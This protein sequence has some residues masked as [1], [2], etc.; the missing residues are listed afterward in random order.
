[1]IAGIDLHGRR[2]L[3][4]GAADG[5]GVETAR[6]LASAGAETV[7][8]ARDLAAAER[9]AASMV[10]TSVPIVHPSMT[11]NA[12]GFVGSFAHVGPFR[13][14]HRT[15]ATVRPMTQRRFRGLILDF[16]GVLTSNMVEVIELFEAREH[17]RPG[18][19]LKSWASAEGQELYRQLE[20]GTI[21]QRAWNEGLAA[22]LG[23]T[24]GNL[25]GRLLY[26]LDPAH[27][28]LKVARQAKAAG[29]R[30]AVLSN[31][32][33]RDPFD[34]YASYKLP[35]LVDVI[36]LSDECG[37][38]KPDPAIFQLTLD[39]LRVPA[40]SCV[41]ADDTEAN[42]ETAAEMGMTVIHALDEQETASRLRAVLGLAS[43]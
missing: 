11:M 3:V 16:A 12:I 37:I 10:A 18:S 14:A 26:F 20:L 13:L 38:R 29:I 39:Q 41:F 6:A 24:A 33:G 1:M 17:L 8:A 30:T 2:A 15:A 34:P 27:D 28:V 32:L 42:L 7:I 35:D 5:I 21:S 31:S 22:L 40:A 19:F 9:T 23:T 43:R 4:T 36:V 25:M